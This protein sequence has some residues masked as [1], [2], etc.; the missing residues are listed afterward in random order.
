VTAAVEAA[1]A[2]SMAAAAARASKVLLLRLP[3]G[4]PRLRGT[5]GVTAGTFA[6]F[7]LP[8]GWPH[9]RPPDLLG[10]PALAPPK[11]SVDDMEAKRLRELLGEEEE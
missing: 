7:L 4:Q 1:P 9:L 2:D 10:T 6:L 3:G 5:G 8:N 11:A